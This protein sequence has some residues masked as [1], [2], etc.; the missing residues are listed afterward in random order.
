MEINNSNRPFER[1]A[2]AVSFSPRIEGVIAE[3]VRY[4]RSMNAD[5]EFYEFVRTLDAYKK[6]IPA[7]SRLILSTDSEF[8]KKLRKK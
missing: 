8:L 3:S 2:V 7:D 1:I 6:S 4:A 5:P